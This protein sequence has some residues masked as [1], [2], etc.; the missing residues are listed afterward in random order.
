MSPPNLTPP[1]PA[2]DFFMQKGNLIK[3]FVVPCRTS[4]AIQNGVNND[5][6]IIHFVIYGERK[7]F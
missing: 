6:I 5:I 2:K 4:A 7:A 1:E 3:L